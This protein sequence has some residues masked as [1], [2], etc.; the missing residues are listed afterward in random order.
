MQPPGNTAGNKD[1]AVRYQRLVRRE[2]GARLGRNWGHALAACPRPLGPARNPG[3]R[4]KGASPIRP[5]KEILLNR[6]VVISGCSSGGKSTLLAELARRGHAV[7][8]EPGRRI[9]R[10]GVLPWID[11]AA[12]ARR[13]VAMALADREAADGLEGW[14][15]FDRGL[16]DAVA[17]LEHA[18]GEAVLEPLGRAH[19]Y[20]LRVFLTPPWPEIYINDPERPHGFEAARAEYERLLTAYAALDYDVSILPKIDVA[21]RTDFVLATLRN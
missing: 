11:A 13:A 1:L 21:A 16:V 18:M 14:V 3:A 12:F 19:R 5:W 8:E 15:F 4:H 6:F 17:A 9:V 20:H 10:E 2:T 7:V